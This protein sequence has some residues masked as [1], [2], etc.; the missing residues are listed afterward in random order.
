MQNRMKDTLSDMLDEKLIE[1]EKS[2]SQKFLI[3]KQRKLFKCD[4]EGC[5][6]QF[7]EKGNL[8]THIR[9]HVMKI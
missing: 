1:L 3:Q 9:I 5:N 8:K 7:R 2:H 6:R 4:Y